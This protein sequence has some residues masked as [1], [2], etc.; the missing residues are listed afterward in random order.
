ME[1]TFSISPFGPFSPEGLI[2]LASLAGIFGMISGAMLMVGLKKLAGRVVL[3]ALFFAILVGI[4][5][6]G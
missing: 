6:S 1:A 5:I 3:L 4:G 2:I